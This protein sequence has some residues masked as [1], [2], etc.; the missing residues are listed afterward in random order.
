MRGRNP[1]HQKPCPKVVEARRKKEQE[2]LKRKTKA[3]EGPSTLPLKRRKNDVAAVE[4]GA[5]LN[6]TVDATPLNHAHPSVAPVQ[7]Q[8]NPEEVEREDAD[9]HAAHLAFEET[10]QDAGVNLTGEGNRDEVPHP[11]R[12]NTPP[13]HMA[14]PEG[15]QQPCASDG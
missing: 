4:V 10:D 9:G 2:A 5:S 3:G 6:D 1:T 14:S 15:E 8:V 13:V 12:G 11:S 7:G